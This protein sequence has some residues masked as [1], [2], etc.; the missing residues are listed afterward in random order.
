[1]S[2]MILVL[3]SQRIEPPTSNVGGTA[4]TAEGAFWTS[5]SSSSVCPSSWLCASHPRNGVGCAKF[6]RSTHLLKRECKVSDI[7]FILGDRAFKGWSYAVLIA[8]L[9]LC[10]N[11]P[12]LSVVGG[13][14][15]S[16]KVLVDISNGVREREGYDHVP[17]RCAGFKFYFIGYSRANAGEWKR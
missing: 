3:L 17:R 15:L 5:T 14:T 1:M 11:N 6:L 9:S 16:L 13:S 10:L 2:F 4:G 12:A 8:V 7:I